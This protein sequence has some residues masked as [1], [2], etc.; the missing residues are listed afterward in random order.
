MNQTEQQI[1][2]MLTESTGTHFLDSGGGSG[3]HWQRNIKKSLNEFRNEKIFTYEPDDIYSIEKS[4]FHHLNETT[5]YNMTLT[6]RLNNFL[7]I[8]N[9]DSVLDSV[10]MFL[11]NQ[12]Q[13]ETTRIINTYNDDCI[14]SQTLQF[15]TVGDT[16]KYDVIALSIHNGADVRGGYTDYKIFNIDTD[17]FFM[18]HPS[19]YEYLLDTDLKEIS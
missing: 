6:K 13:G 19:H 10:D 14:L 5:Q 1:Y 4:V 7:K 17:T 15:I 2:N 8:N 9:Y 18:W 16:Y 3:R 12:Y 11:K